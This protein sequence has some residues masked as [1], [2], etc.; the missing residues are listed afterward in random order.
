[1]KK[2]KK[3]KGLYRFHVFVFLFNVM[4]IIEYLK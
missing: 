1:L 4:K 3:Y 2:K